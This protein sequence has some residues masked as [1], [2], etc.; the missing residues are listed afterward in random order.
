MSLLFFSEWFY[1]TVLT[2]AALVLSCM[3]DDPAPIL[4]VFLSLA[5]VFQMTAGCLALWKGYDDALWVPFA[6]AMSLGVLVSSLVYVA[7]DEESRNK[8]VL[9]FLSLATASR[10]VFFIFAGPLLVGVPDVPRGEREGSSSSITI[11]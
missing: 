4:I 7:T 8:A 10:T 5:A 11:V 9:I 6:G 1:T 3:A 2:L